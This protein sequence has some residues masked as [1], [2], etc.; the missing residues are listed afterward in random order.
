MRDTPRIHPCRLIG[1]IHAAD[2]HALA[3]PPAL[4]YSGIAMSLTQRYADTLDEIRA[5]GLYKSERIITSPQSAEI[6]LADGRKVL[7]HQLPI[8]DFQKGFDL[9]EQGKAGKVVLSW[10]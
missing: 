5:A 10:N 4:L 3:V 8:D 2:G 1:G 6:T 9:M 7:T